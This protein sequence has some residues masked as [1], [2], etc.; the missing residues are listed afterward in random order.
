MQTV[1][2]AHLL[3]EQSGTF[4]SA[5]KS[6]GVSA[7][8]YDIQDEYGHTDVKSDIFQEIDNFF[9]GKKTIF[10]TFSSFDIVFAFFPCTYFC[11]NNRMFFT[12]KH[13]NI[14]SLSDIDK[15]ESLIE[16]AKK[17]NLYYIKLLQLVK[18]SK[19]LKFRLVVENPF[20]ANSYL[21]N[22]LYFDN[23][24]FIRDRR[25]LGDYFQKPTAFFC[26]NF[27]PNTPALRIQYF[28]NTQRF[29]SK[30]HAGKERSE[31][32]FAFAY[33]FIKMYIL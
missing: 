1:S 29:V 19:I 16:R 13:R 28:Q 24:I 21:Y 26:Y 23:L 7:R 2:S 14:Y 17:R 9:I 5:F 31:I 32:S 11:E 6:L 3:F 27:K 10:D 25:E 12:G 18:I 33:N 8:C 30:I 20:N 15:I 22:N 4:K